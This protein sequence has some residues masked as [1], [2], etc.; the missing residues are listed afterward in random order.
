[1]IL[2]IK[3]LLASE[4]AIHAEERHQ[5][6]QRETLPDTTEPT[7]QVDYEVLLDETE[8]ARW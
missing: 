3:N 7:V 5:R 1:M 2:N 4:A 8:A 6:E